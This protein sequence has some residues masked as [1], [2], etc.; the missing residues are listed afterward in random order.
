MD[1]LQ[2][3]I[4]L[5]ISLTITIVSLNIATDLPFIEVKFPNNNI[6]LRTTPVKNQ[7]SSIP[8]RVGSDEC[9]LWTQVC[10]DEILRL[11]HEPENV[12]WLKRVRRTIH[13]NPELAFE[14]FETS[15][16][17]RTELDR[18]DIRYKYPLAKTGIRAWIGSGGAPF[19]AVRADMDALPIQG[20]VIVLFQPAEEAGNGAKKMIEDGALDDVEAIFAVH[21]SHEHPTGVI[22]SRSGPLLA[23]CGFFRAIITSEE[24]GSSADLIIAASSAVISLQGIVSRE[25]S[26]LDAQ[27]VSVTSFDGGHSLDAMPDTVVLGGTFRAFSNSSFYYLMKR[28]REVLVEQVGVFG[29]KATLN[30]FEE[31]NAIYPPTTNDDGMYTHLKKVTVDLLGDNNF[32]VAPQVMGAEDFA[33]YSEV[34]PAAFYF[35]GIRNEELGSVH[36]GHSPHFMIDEDSLPVGAAVHAAVA[37]RYL[38]DKRS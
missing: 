26:P 36:I 17:V 1:S 21:V 13:E 32:A 37:E 2:K 38:N 34:I 27:V 7:S 16:L 5:F 4:L 14:E 3:L 9:R 33:F 10:S 35:I 22:G 19:V 6:L 11:A 20:T 30:F 18:L 15:R 8:S 28:I 31:Q 25:A 23:G 12:A 29:C 24:S